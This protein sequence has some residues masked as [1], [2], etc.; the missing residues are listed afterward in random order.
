MQIPGPLGHGTK[1]RKV[2]AFADD[3]DVWCRDMEDVTYL[4]APNV[5][6]LDMWYHASAQV[7]SVDKFTIV[8]LGRSVNDA[9][10]SIRSRIPAK[11]WVVYGRDEADKQL[12]I[13]IGD[14]IQVGSQWQAMVQ[15]VE[16]LAIDIAAGRRLGGSQ[17]VRAAIAKGAFASKVYHTFKAQ[18][19]FE[20]MRALALQRIQDS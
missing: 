18:A 20:S 7:N 3:I 19:P 9:T 13:R 8:L 14:P 17:Y 12:G 11:S 16:Q 5:G 10:E 4:A 6:P 15:R 2:G 1:V